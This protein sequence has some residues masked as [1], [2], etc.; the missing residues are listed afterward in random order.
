MKELIVKKDGQQIVLMD[1][2]D[3]IDALSEKAN[4]NEVSTNITAN[5]LNIT[6]DKGD[7]SEETMNQFYIEINGNKKDI[8]YTVEENGSYS[9][10]K[11]DSD[12]LDDLS[13]DWDDIQNKPDIPTKTSELENDS[14]FVSVEVISSMEN[15]PDGVFLLVQRTIFKAIYDF[16]LPDTMGTGRHVAL[17]HLSE[18]EVEFIEWGDGSITSIDKNIHYDEHMYDESQDIYTLKMEKLNKIPSFMMDG[19]SFLTDVIIP[20]TVTEMGDGCFVNCTDLK[21]VILPN[22]LKS[23]PESCFSS[24]SNLTSINIPD[25]VTRLENG[26]FSNSGLTSIRLSQGLKEMKEDCLSYTNLTSIDIPNSVTYLSGLNGTKITS[27][28]IPNSVTIIGENCFENCKQ[29]RSINIPNSVTKILRG[30]FAGCNNLHIKVPSSVTDIMEGTFI[31]CDNITVELPSTITIM[32]LYLFEGDN[33]TC[34]LNWK[35]NQIKD[36][37]S[38]MY[39]SPI[40]FIVP[41]GERTNYLNKGYPSDSVTERDE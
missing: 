27:I 17:S 31:G 3:I 19:S 6:T 28:D 21:S 41:A 38:D 11:L 23:I 15:L 36:Y 22:G 29:L 1:K 4:K 39:R 37:D 8:Y 26:C 32:D 14:G 35:G 5:I 30:A 2:N 33:I 7:A 20:D 24:C 34:I 9:W 40:N 25:T 12:I 16:S 10:V 13:I 18:T